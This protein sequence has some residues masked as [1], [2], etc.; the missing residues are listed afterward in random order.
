MNV[1]PKL[2]IVG[3]KVPTERRKNTLFVTTKI[4]MTISTD[5]VVIM[6]FEA[7]ESSS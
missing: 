2:A 7:H 3:S 5:S 1:L 6:S 4:S